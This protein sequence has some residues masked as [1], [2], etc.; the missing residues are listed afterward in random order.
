MQKPVSAKPAVQ[1]R[2]ERQAQKSR[3]NGYEKKCRYCPCRGHLFLARSH[4]AREQD[5]QHSVESKDE[6]RVREDSGGNHPGAIQGTR[7]DESSHPELTVTRIARTQPQ[8]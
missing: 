7:A 5:Q 8:Q 3:R 1:R 4:S 2:P 6:Y